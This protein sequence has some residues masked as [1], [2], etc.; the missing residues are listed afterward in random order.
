MNKKSHPWSSHMSN[1]MTCVML[2]VTR[3]WFQRTFTHVQCYSTVNASIYTVSV[4]FVI[5]ICAE[6]LCDCSLA[7]LL[8][9]SGF[10]PLVFIPALFNLP[11]SNMADALSPSL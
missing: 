10:L 9:S 4:L 5:C 7:V 8:L 6:Q 2:H 1:A 11:Q 3:L